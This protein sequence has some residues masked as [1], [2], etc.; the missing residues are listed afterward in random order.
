[1]SA[2]ESFMASIILSAL[3]AF[4][5][6]LPSYTRQSSKPE[7]PEPEPPGRGGRIGIVS[8]S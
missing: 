7:P 6:N 5:V 2:P 4:S 1:M 3:A 8:Q